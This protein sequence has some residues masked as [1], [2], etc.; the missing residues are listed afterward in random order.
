ML[1]LAEVKSWKRKLEIA[2]VNYKKDFPSII[3]SEMQFQLWLSSLLM[4]WKNTEYD[5]DLLACSDI[6]SFPLAES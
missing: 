2:L 6:V 1:I 4:Q 3:D 5:I